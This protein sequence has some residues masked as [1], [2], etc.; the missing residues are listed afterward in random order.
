MRPPP[1]NIT[2]CSVEAVEAEQLEHKPPSAALQR[3]P[4]VVPGFKMMVASRDYGL[5][6]PSDGTDHKIPLW[7]ELSADV[8]QR[9]PH[10]W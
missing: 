4:E 3:Q 1:S 10:Q 5:V 8:A 7:L 2:R 9:A 6:G